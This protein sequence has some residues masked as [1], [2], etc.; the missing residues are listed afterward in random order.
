MT[1][2]SFEEIQ[3]K[4]QKCYAERDYEGA[5]E[6]ATI[7]C[8]QFPEHRHVLY[9]LRSTMAARIGDYDLAISILE[10]MLNS[11]FWYGEVLL[12]GSPSYE[13]LQGLPEFEQ[14]VT[15]NRNLQELDHEQ[16]LHLLTI[17]GEGKCLDVG[18]PCPLLLGLHANASNAQ[19]SIDF[20]RAAASDGW[21][22]AVPQSSQAL[23]KGA[24]LWDDRETSASEVQHHYQSIIEQYAVNQESTILAG[25]SMGGEMAA[26]MVLSGTLSAQGFIAFGPGG[27]FIDALENWAAL[28][29]QAAGTGV[30]G[31]IILGEEDDTVP[32][33]NI[34]TFVEMLNQAEI[35]CQ[36]EIVPQAGHEFVPQYEASLLRAIRFVNLDPA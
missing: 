9:Y 23:W 6:T 14:L 12:R 34:I 19:A 30:R 3:T 31:C 2:T 33:E 22:V 1:D 13:A 18:D 17:R 21:L 36:L 8:D 29:E 16:T 35:P 7:F 25:H 11:G 26:W 20:W 24:Y 4:I 32:Q 5:Y 28:I 27:P 15:L 10:E